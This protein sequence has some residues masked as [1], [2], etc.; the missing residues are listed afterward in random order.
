[1]NIEASPSSQMICAKYQVHSELNFLYQFWIHTELVPFISKNSMGM[2]DT[3]QRYIIFLCPKKNTTFKRIIKGP[4]HWTSGVG[5]QHSFAPSRSPWS[6]SVMVMMM[7]IEIMI[8]IMLILKYTIIKDLLIRYCLDKN[9]A[10][11][12]IIWDRY[13]VI[14]NVQKELKSRLD[15][16]Q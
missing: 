4:E 5:S 11:V 13:C 7:T 8:T 1:M 3:L 9:Y 6:Q 10:G 2:I 16:R 12:L 14:I 15:L